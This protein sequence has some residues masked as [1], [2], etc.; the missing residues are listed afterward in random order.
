MWVDRSIR[1]ICYFQNRYLTLKHLQ[2]MVGNQKMCQSITVYAYSEKQLCRFKKKIFCQLMTLILVSF[3]L[4][5]FYFNGISKIIGYLILSVVLW[6]KHHYNEPI[7]SGNSLLY[8]QSWL[9]FPPHCR[10]ALWKCILC[11]I[12]DFA[13][14]IHELSKIWICSYKTKFNST[15]TYATLFLVANAGEFYFSLQFQCCRV[16]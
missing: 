13:V 15:Y 3:G 11:C 9:A 8:H 16:W 5:F 14:H 7:V 6:P 2:N 1:T 4:G 10:N 12:Y